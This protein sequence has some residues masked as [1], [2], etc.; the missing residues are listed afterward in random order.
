[1]HICGQ[2]PEDGL[3]LRADLDHLR[4][5]LDHLHGDLPVCAAEGATRDV[6]IFCPAAFVHP[7]TL[8]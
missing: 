2:F 8:L 3:N 5:D 7:V 1:M 4:V 6:P